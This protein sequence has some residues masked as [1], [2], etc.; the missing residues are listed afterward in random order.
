MKKSLIITI[1]ITFSIFSLFATDVYSETS[2]SEL[3]LPISF[4]TGTVPAFAVG[5]STVGSDDTKFPDVVN[6]PQK[7]EPV[8]ESLSDGNGELISLK[9]SASYYIYWIISGQKKVSVKLKWTNQKNQKK[10]EDIFI[11]KSMDEAETVSEGSISYGTV[12]DTGSKKIEISTID[13]IDEPINTTYKLA[14][15]LEATS[16]S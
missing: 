4:T 1:L 9:A 6:T 2:G 12:T 15:T 16:G 8:L 7:V 11:V 3:T 13:L 5:F 14:L 10:D